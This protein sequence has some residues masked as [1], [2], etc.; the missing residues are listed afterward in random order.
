MGRQWRQCVSRLRL[1]H[2]RDTQQRGSACA[3]DN[4]MNY[5]LPRRRPL[6]VDLIGRFNRVRR[7][8]KRDSAQLPRRIKRETRE[9]FSRVLHC[10]LHRTCAIYVYYVMIALV[11]YGCG[12]F[13]VRSISQA[14][15]TGRACYTTRD[16]FCE[17]SINHACL[18]THVHWVYAHVYAC[19]S[20]CVPPWGIVGW[21]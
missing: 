13:T 17:W 4:Q 21:G 8:R 9:R 12:W 7:Q 15:N 6:A 18:V 16:C 10:T 1:S 2:V 14:G 20:V 11:W 3:T 5:W 19:V